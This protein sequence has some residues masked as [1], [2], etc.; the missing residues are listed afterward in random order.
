VANLDNVH[1]VARRDLDSRI[2][3]L[4]A[5]RVDEVKRALG[6]ALDWSELKYGEREKD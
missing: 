4:P 1:V 3:V 5:P 2:G 6:H